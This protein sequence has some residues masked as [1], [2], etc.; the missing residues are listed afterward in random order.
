M[1]DNPEDKLLKPDHVWHG[2]AIGW[3]QNLNHA[4]NYLVS[5][6]ERIAGIKLKFADTSIILISFYAPTSGKDE[7]FSEA[8]SSLS[9]FIIQHTTEDNEQVVIGTDS[10]CSSKSSARRQLSL[11]LSSH[12]PIITTLYIEDISKPQ[13]RKV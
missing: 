13:E 8:V 12:I 11:N 3:Q 6:N 9:E 1:F 5:N 2:V 7:E 10:N 4:I